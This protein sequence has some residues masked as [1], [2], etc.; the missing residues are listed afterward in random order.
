M[1]KLRVGITHGDFN[2]VGYEVILKTVGAD[3]V[4]DLYTPVVFGDPRIA[5]RAIK[6]MNLEP[7]AFNVV[8]SASEVQDDMINIV[9]LQLSDIGLNPGLPT[10][11]SG[12]SSVK[13]LDEAV[14]ALEEGD[15]DVL[16]TAPISKEAVQSNTFRF[17]GHTEFLEARAGEN[18]KADMILFDDNM[19][20]AL[21][22]TH[23]PIS[24]VAA[25]VTKEKV[26]AAIERLNDTLKRDFGVERPKIAVLSLNPH[27]GDG[28][29]LGDEE[30]KEIIPAIEEA[31][32]EKIL[33][34][35]P[36]AADGFFASGAFSRY[37][38]VLAMF[39][40]QGLAPFKA[41][42]RDGGVNFTAGLPWVRTSP[43]HG[44]AYD[45]AWKGLADP[46]SMRQAV[47]KAI[48]IFRRRERFDEA[49][50]NPLKKAH[51]TDRPE[52]PERKERNVE[53]NFEKETEL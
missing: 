1:K 17:P 3:G 49:S 51:R 27:C 33:A 42:A 38:V 7:V 15:I 53:K 19:R 4:L 31:V 43:D 48:D 10:K 12:I 11:V 5:E 30:Q 36:F 2:G 23:L 32:A 34:F 9:D 45:I 29:V 21:L 44:T 41:L 18:T 50:A 13:A 39:H 47:Y 24:S 26:L 37:D 28:G 46:E 8:K 52:R 35:G 40:D 25:A 14:K 16:V 6:E 22:S 20:V